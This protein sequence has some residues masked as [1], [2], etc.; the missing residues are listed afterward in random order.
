VATIYEV[1]D[2]QTT[3][4]VGSFQTEAEARALL[5]DILRVNG[6]DVAREMVIVAYFPDGP[7]PREPVMVLDGAD[8]VTQIAE[9]VQQGRTATA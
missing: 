2:S 6:A 3:N 7:S 4:Q 5:A 8:F 1:W 9:R